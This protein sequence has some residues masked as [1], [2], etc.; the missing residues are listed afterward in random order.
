M[1]ELS[2]DQKMK[3]QIAR[4]EG[5]VNSDIKKATES[6]K[7][8]EVPVQGPGCTVFI[9][10]LRSRA[11]GY[12]RP[13]KEEIYENILSSLTHEGNTHGLSK[14]QEMD[15]EIKGQET[16]K[17]K[18]HNDKL[19]IQKELKEL[20]TAPYDKFMLY[21][22]LNVKRGAQGDIYRNDP[23]RSAVLPLQKDYEKRQRVDTFW[24]ILVSLI[25]AAMDFNIIYNVFLSSNMALRSAL[26]SSLLSAVML[27]I[28][29]YV[30]GNL[31]QRKNDRKRLWVMRGKLVSKAAQV[32]LKPYTIGIWL[33]IVAIGLFFVMYLML[34]IILF[35][36]GGDFDLA[37]HFLLEW[38][39]DFSRVE[40]NSSDFISTLF[41]IVTSAVAFVFGLTRFTSYVSH[42]EK[43]NTVIGDV[44]KLQVDNCTEIENKCEEEKVNLQR[45][46]NTM[47]RE[48][49]T[50]YFKQKPVPSKEEEFEQKVSAEFQ[51]I[52]L[53][54][55][56]EIYRTLCIHLRN[57]ARQALTKINTELAPQVA[58]Q[59][60]ITTME[61]SAEEQAVLDSFWVIGK[62]A[63]QH[64]DTARHMEKIEEWIQ[65]LVQPDKGAK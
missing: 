31:L 50:F 53:E 20:K 56:I 27:D 45:R 62:N 24:G 55:Y 39:F 35:F 28:P 29:P 32:D 51:R 47:K 41:P 6:V 18:A 17:K 59:T 36:G 5:T 54:M 23:I 10:S 60:E 49:W 21:G 4:A 65:K 7:N 58:S 9:R 26:I 38:E 2:L 43:T 8:H 12:F 64:E 3:E 19:R 61:F 1:P 48:I 42:I 63:V 11:L 34:R 46:R 40:F 57:R 14:L 37:L 25:F 15:S 52:N 30:L 22:D 33:L 16:K 44:L 13:V